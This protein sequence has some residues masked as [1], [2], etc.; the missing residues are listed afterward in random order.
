[1]SKQQIL[2]NKENWSVD[3]W[4]EVRWPSFTWCLFKVWQWNP[5]CS[6]P[7][8][9]LQNGP[10]SMAARVFRSYRPTCRDSRL[11]PGPWIS[12]INDSRKDEEKGFH[13]MTN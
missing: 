4:I 1:M 12:T 13:V 8:L 9:G 5:S 2:M 11:I 6:L 3:L 7:C 10:E